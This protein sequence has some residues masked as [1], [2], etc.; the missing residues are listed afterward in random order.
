MAT[1][2]RYLQLH[3][4]REVLK[5]RALTGVVIITNVIGNVTLS[6]G[7]RQV[8]SITRFDIEPYL[9]AFVNGWVLIGVVVLAVWMLSE[10]ALLSRADLSFV[11][12]VTSISYVLIAITG[13]FLLGEHI[14]ATRWAGIL[15]ITTGVV[16]VGETPPR[17]TDETEVEE[18]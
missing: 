6:H 5:T 4:D 13:E 1:L 7:M 16:L 9:R 15:V 8:G 14:S 2:T 18:E 12:P 3:G 17:T 11:L 10:L